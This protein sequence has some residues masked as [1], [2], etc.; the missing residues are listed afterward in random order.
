[1]KILEGVLLVIHILGLAAV[2]FGLLRQLNRPTKVVDALIAHGATTQLVTGVLLLGVLES[3]DEDVNHVKFGI[4][5]LVG[6]VVVGLA[7]ANR[8]KPSIPNGIF[9]GLIALELLNAVLA[10]AW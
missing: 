8:R 10:L 7:H 5:L 4:K 6:L 1:M 3:G 2:A 9:F